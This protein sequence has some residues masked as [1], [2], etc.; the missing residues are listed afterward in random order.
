LTATIETDQAE[1]LAEQTAEFGLSDTSKA[2]RVLI[3]YAIQEV[4]AQLI[5]AN[6]N[7]RC[8]HCG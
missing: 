2:L 8:R 1:W 6:E 5:F 3:D 4:D 7:A